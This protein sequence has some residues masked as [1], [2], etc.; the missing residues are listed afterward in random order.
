LREGTTKQSLRSPRYVRDDRRVMVKICG[1]RSVESAIAVIEKGADFVGFNFV[2]N[3]KRRI[4]AKTAKE[5]ISKI[6]GQINIVGVFQNAD[7]DYINGLIQDLGLDYVQ[8]HGNED[9]EFS[10]KINSKVIKAIS[11]QVNNDVEQ[12][13]NLMKKYTVEYF[14][15]DRE[16]QGVGDMIN[17]EKAKIIADK[18]PVFLAGGLNPDNVAGI[19]QTVG[20]FAVDV[21]GGI[22]TDR[23][24]DLDKIKQFIISAKGVTI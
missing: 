12:Q 16:I 18:V 20:P 13:I 7:L 23:V 8:L 4:D 3:S 11:M 15:L 21:A 14:L 19:V 6:K 24:E 17:S 10:Q 9:P 5:I 1:I 2:E 22:E